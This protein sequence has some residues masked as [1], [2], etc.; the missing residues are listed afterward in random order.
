MEID[1]ELVEEIANSLE[2]TNLRLSISQVHE[3]TACLVR[4]ERCSAN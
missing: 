3:M 1:T 2:V 4:T